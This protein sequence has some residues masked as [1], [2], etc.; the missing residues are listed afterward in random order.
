MYS[1]HYFSGRSDL[2]IH[3]VIVGRFIPCLLPAVSPLVPTA[4]F[5]PVEGINQA[6]DGI[7]YVVPAHRLPAYLRPGSC[8]AVAGGQ[9]LPRPGYFG[10]PAHSP[11]PFAFDHDQ[12]EPVGQHAAGGVAAVPDYERAFD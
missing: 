3:L 8:Q 9:L 1:I 11:E 7:R 5:C 10:N 6:K 4:A 12:V 2:R